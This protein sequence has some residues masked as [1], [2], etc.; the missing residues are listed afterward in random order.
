MRTC[1]ELGAVALLLLLI[2]PAK[3]A[4]APTIAID[5]ASLGN[6][7][8]QG[9]TPVLRVTVSGDT[10][11]GMRGRLEVE[12]T[13][14]YQ[15]GAG[16]ARFQV[17][18]APGTTKTYEFTIRSRR[19]GHFSVAARLTDA[20]NRT[21]A[22]HDT[23]AGLVL[24][25][26]ASPAED[27]AVGYFVFP[28]EGEQPLADA[29]AADMRRFGIRWVRLTFNWWNDDRM[30]RPD[31]DDP[32]WLDSSTFEHWVDAF[33]ANGIE[34]LGVLF[35]TARWASSFSE[36]EEPVGGI[37]AWGLV[38]PRDLGDWER[39]VRTLAE[40]MRG[41][42]GSWEVWNEPDIPLFWLSSTDEYVALLRST[43]AVLRD[44]DP[45]TRVVVNLVDRDSARGLAFNE[46]VVAEAA[47][48]LDVF[49]LHYGNSATLAASRAVLPRLRPGG[50]LWNTEAYGAPRRFISRWLEHRVSGIDRVFPFVYH[51]PFDDLAV[52]DLVRFGRYPVNLDY[53]PR[54]DALALRTLSDLVG[55]GEAG[56]FA[57]VG[58]GW[59]TYAF[60]TRAGPVVALVDGND[61]GPTWSGPPGLTLWIGNLPPELRRL[62]VVDLM[63]NRRVVRVRRGRAR[64]R[65]L[66]MGAFLLPD[67]PTS[68]D[69][70]VVY[71]IRAA[72]H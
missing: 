34:V 14:A 61:L 31:L 9:E 35:G 45:R 28:F 47:H 36:L 25:V 40:R 6:V 30:F 43:A 13:D 44:V 72:R 51:M 2:V 59:S 49:G 12:A 38:G 17:N 63:G 64:L 71:R 52:D 10:D 11:A 16:R 48:E 67:P 29:V 53:S 19:L 32:A 39:F 65:M 21:V 8:E 23:T 4:A 57:S 46:R 33:R 42:V 18:L 60:E 22:R 50:A 54:P 41:R 27:S 37:P 70:L 58:L 15:R 3:A 5:S 56:L 66:G 20:R 1:R 26:D 24:P 62:I 68:L 69:G 55:V 7:F